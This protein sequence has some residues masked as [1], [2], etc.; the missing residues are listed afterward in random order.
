[1]AKPALAPTSD[2]EPIDRL[3]DKIKLLVDMVAR[4]RA[5]QERAADETERLRREMESLRARLSEA[6]S[7]NAELTALREERD[8]IRSRVAQMLAQLDTI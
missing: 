1:M 4:L 5:D 6:D 8:T 7:A 3:E 2:L